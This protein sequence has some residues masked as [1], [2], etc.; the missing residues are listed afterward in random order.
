MTASKKIILPAMH[1]RGF[2]AGSV[3][4]L[5][6]CKRQVRCLLG[7]KGTVILGIILKAGTMHIGN[8]Y[9]YMLK[10]RLG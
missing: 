7:T 5:L 4:G 10:D 9:I 6:S 8:I 2:G 3:V 1:R